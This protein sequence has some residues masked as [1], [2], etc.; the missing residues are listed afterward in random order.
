ALVPRLRAVAGAAA[1]GEVATVIGPAL[2]LRQDVVDLGRWHA[3]CAMH[4]VRPAC[5]EGFLDQHT[6]ACPAPVGAVLTGRRRGG[7]H[8]VAPVLILIFVR[9]SAPSSTAVSSA[10]ARH[11]W[12]IPSR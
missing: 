9:R 3:A 8:G 1:A 5:A 6:R 12:A 10:R 4:A 2:R 7:S 11:A